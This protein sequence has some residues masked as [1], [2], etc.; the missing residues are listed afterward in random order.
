MVKAYKP[1]REIFEKALEFSG[2]APHEVIH[3]GDSVISDVNGAF[4]TGIIPCLFDRSGTKKSEKYMV[5]SSL[6]EVLEKL[7]CCSAV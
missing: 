5:C 3:I 6:I 7:S 1:H 4:D 2:Y